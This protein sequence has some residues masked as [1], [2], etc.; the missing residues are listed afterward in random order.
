MNVWINVA[1][2]LHILKNPNYF[3]I[4]TETIE[5]KCNTKSFYLY[6][7]IYIY[8][9]VRH[10]FGPCNRVACYPTY[11][12]SALVMDTRIPAQ[13]CRQYQSIKNPRRYFVIQCA[14]N[15]N[16]Q[17]ILDVNRCNKREICKEF[18]LLGNIFRVTGHLCGEFTGHRWIPHKGQWR[19]AL[20][21]SLICVWINGCVNNGKAGDLR[22]HRF[23]YDVIVMLCGLLQDDSDSCRF[24]FKLI[25]IVWAANN[26]TSNVIPRDTL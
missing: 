2:H 20:M 18:R 26:K 14:R 24:W 19:R 3:L 22:H 13:E 6:Q 10:S 8:T 1:M 7:N 23:Q 21:F 11:I 4:S 12:P 25:I 15:S 9:L 5:M 16:L 17:L